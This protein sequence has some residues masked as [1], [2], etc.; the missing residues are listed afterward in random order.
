MGGPSFT[1]QLARLEAHVPTSTVCLPAALLEITTPLI[2][3]VWERELG[4]HPDSSF[5]SYVVNGVKRGFRVGYNSSKTPTSC[6]SNMASALLHPNVVSHYLE[7]ELLLNRII[8][9]NRPAQV[10]HIHCQISPFLSQRKQ[11]RAN[12]AS[13]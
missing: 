13:L 1:P 4:S 7:Q 6:G 5:A 3:E 8:V 11:N 12:G 9:V 2:S 10:L